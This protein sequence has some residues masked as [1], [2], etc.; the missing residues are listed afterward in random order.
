MN[1][2]SSHNLA[3]RGRPVHQ[4]ICEPGN[5][6]VIIFLTVCTAGRRPILATPEMQVHLR[7]AWR[8]SDRWLVGRFVVMPDHIHLFCAPGTIHPESLQSWVG[9]WKRLTAFATGGSFWQKSFWDTQL[10]REDSYALKWEYV[11]NNPVR[12]GLVMRLEDWPYQGEL[13]VLRWNE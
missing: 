8:R 12:A 5:R 6:A 11:R 10:R 7:E 3:R 4:S 2:D 13:N 9:Y 1:S